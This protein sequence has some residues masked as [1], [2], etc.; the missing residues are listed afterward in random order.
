MTDASGEVDRVGRV[1][2]RCRHELEL[3]G[4]KG[5]T[6]RAPSELHLA[7][8]LVRVVVGGC[9]CR[10]MR[11]ACRSICAID[12]GDGVL[13]HGES[14]SDH[15]GRQRPGQPDE[16]RLIHGNHAVTCRKRGIPRFDDVDDINTSAT[17]PPVRRSPT[18]P[19]EEGAT[20]SHPCPAVSPSCWTN[21]TLPDGSRSSG[22]SRRPDGWHG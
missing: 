5:E 2:L 7:S 18:T 4:E 17:N 11:S 13:P 6:G 19:F 10:G 1:I 15:A 8:T 12:G 14:V 21:A 20:P 9:G 16:L 3:A 22:M